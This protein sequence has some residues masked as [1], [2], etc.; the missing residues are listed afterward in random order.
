MNFAPQG[1]TMTF[2][3]AMFELNK[4]FNQVNETRAGIHPHPK[5]DTRIGIEKTS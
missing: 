2:L 4:T 3:L 5:R 1:L